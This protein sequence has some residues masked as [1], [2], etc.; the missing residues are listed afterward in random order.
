MSYRAGGSQTARPGCSFSRAV[1]AWGHGNWLRRVFAQRLAYTTAVDWER[2]FQGDSI[3]ELVT[4]LHDES[5]GNGIRQRAGSRFST[6]TIRPCW[7]RGQMIN[8]R[9]VS[10]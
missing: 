10:S 3:C 2:Q 7:Q 6:I 8:D 5:T 1:E 9:P 4:M